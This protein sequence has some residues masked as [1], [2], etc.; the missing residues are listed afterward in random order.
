MKKFLYISVLSSLVVL[1]SCKK[2]ADD[3]NSNP[4]SQFETME[5]LKVSG[6]FNYE[7]FGDY[8][9]TLTGYTD[10][11][12]EVLSE[13]GVIFQR[14]YLKKDQPYAMKLTVPTYVQ[15]VKLRFKGKEAELMLDSDKLSYQFK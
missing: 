2:D 9:L 13:K 15:E 6:E 5:N 10:G 11:V 8:N 1:T 14:A 3:P 12:V 7:T 4:D